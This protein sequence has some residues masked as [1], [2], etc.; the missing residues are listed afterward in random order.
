MKSVRV[1]KR[2]E[3]GRRHAAGQAE[4]DGKSKKATN[5]EREVAAAVT[6]WVSE[7]RHKRRVESGRTFADLFTLTSRLPAGSSPGLTQTP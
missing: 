2:D 1:V 3:R 7:L 5:P 4:V 6:Q